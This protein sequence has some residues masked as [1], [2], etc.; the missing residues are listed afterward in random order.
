VW[1]EVWRN[2][3][4]N[5]P[6]A[7]CASRGSA[8]HLLSELGVS[9]VP[10]AF[11]PQRVRAGCPSGRAPVLLRLLTGP[12]VGEVSAEGSS[13]APLIGALRGIGASEPQQLVRT[14]EIPG[15]DFLRRLGRFRAR[16]HGGLG[17]QFSPEHG[18]ELGHG[19]IEVQFVQEDI[20]LLR[21]LG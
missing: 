2:L 1:W 17:P 20:F 12:Q 14:A 10:A 4:C 16:S 11:V 13:A 3:C 19:F 5:T 15:L 18:A 6:E 7:S 8:N 21:S 9:A